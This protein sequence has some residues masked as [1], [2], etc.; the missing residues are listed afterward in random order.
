MGDR[1]LGVLVGGDTVTV[2]DVEVEA[3][4][5]YMLHDDLTWSLA[6]GDRAKAYADMAQRVEHHV[7]THGISR[8]VVKAS[9]VGGRSVTLAHFHA[10]EL[11][12][13]ILGALAGAGAEV[14]QTPQ[15]Q[16][17]RSF[18]TRKADEYL[19]DNNFWAGQPITGDLRKGS[20]L[21]LLMVIAEHQ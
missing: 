2:V 12:G 8:A 15:A 14:S 4:P 5:E 20:R 3:G 16:L 18:G 21:A 17:S 19:D 6:S 11:R 13:V 9:A 10:A 7:H 1:I